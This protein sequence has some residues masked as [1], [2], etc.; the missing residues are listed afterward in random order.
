MFG[1]EEAARII[2]RELADVPAVTAVI[3][4]RIRFS[5]I[6]PGDLAHPG[7]LVYPAFTQYDGP[8]DTDGTPTYE[9]VDMEVRFIDKGASA[10]TIRAAAK[11][12]LG[13]LA[14]ISGLSE[15]ID[16]VTWFVTFTATAEAGPPH[17]LDESSVYRQLGTVYSVEFHRGG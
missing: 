4:S 12:A 3:G 8:I 10:N 11:A 6:Y 14:G 17:L 13:A 9:R 2:I 16:G 7:A 5:P 15:V 1:T